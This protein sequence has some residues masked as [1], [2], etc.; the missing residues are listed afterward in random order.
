MGAVRLMGKNLQILIQP[1]VTAN[2]VRATIYPAGL[3]T[4]SLASITTVKKLPFTGIT[5]ASPRNGLRRQAFIHGSPDRAIV[6]SKYKRPAAPEKRTL[7]RW[8]VST[9]QEPGRRNS[10]YQANRFTFMPSSGICI[11]GTEDK[12]VGG[13]RS[14]FVD[15]LDVGDDQRSQHR[16]RRR[17]ASP[18]WRS[19]HSPRR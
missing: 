4:G 11:S 6:R 3:T 1:I 16:R 14:L 2:P 10:L 9:A 8:I 18:I 5:G 15:S 12:T 17:I 19:S 7:R 13:G